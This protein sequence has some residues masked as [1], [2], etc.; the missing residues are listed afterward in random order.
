MKS[1]GSWYQ[2]LL[3]S[4]EEITCRLRGQLKLRGSKSTNFVAVGDRVSVDT[5]IEG[6]TIQEVEPRKNYIIRRATNLSRQWHVLAANLD[7]AVLVA[8]LAQPRTSTG[9]IDRF[10]VTCEAY[11]IPAIIVFNKIDLYGERHQED[12]FVFSEIYKSIGYQVL[13]TS[14]STGAGIPELRNILE[15]KVSLISGHS[16]VGKSTL[17]NAVDEHLALRT[18]EISSYH[19][20][21]MHTTTFAEMLRLSFGGFII[22]TPGIKEFGLVDMEKYELSRYFP[23][24]LKIIGDCKFNTCLH[25]NEPGCAVREAVESGEIAEFRYKN[26]LN[27]LNSEEMQKE[28]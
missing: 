6:G 1:T 24:M 20:K 4:G 14:A 26:Y 23:E 21:G 15:D 17:V 27:M 5:S 18:G 3:D 25:E 28:Y 22:D 13:S 16:G 19:K 12:L 11:K 10:L 9:F 8:T 7:Q 2:V